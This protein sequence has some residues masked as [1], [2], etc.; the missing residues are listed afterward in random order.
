VARYWSISAV[1]KSANPPP[2]VITSEVITTK[3]AAAIYGGA[4]NNKYKY[5]IQYCPCGLKYHFQVGVLKGMRFEKGTTLS[6]QK[7]FEFFSSE[8]SIFYCNFMHSAPNRRILSLQTFTTLQLCRRGHV[9]TFVKRVISDK[10]KETSAHFLILYERSMYLIF[11]HE[12]WLVGDVP[13]PFYLKFQ[14]KLTHR[15]QKHRLSIDIRYSAVTH[16]EKS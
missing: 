11:G 9:R 10:T 4:A 1:P 6:P 2:L 7:I 14:A 5:S 13:V 12:Q 15:L 3:L 8:N 16:S